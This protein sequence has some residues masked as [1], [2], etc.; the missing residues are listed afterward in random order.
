[1]KK[2][3]MPDYT[4]SIVNMMA[5]IRKHYGLDINY[6]TLPSLDE[7]LKKNY[8]NVIIVLLDGMGTKII[9][10]SIGTGNFLYKNKKQDYQSIFPPTT[11]AATTAL[12]STK[13]PIENGW[14]GWHIYMKEIDK[15]IAMFM[16]AGYYEDIKYDYSL[17]DLYMPY[18][19]ILDELKT[20]GVTTGDVYPSFRPNGAKDFDEFLVK[21]KEFIDLEGD[22]KFAYCYWTEPDH[23]LH[24]T[25]CTSEVTINTIQELNDKLEIFYNEVLDDDTLIIVT[26]DHGHI[27]ILDLNLAGYPNIL[28]LLERLP[29]IE[30]RAC[31]FYVKEGKE[32]EFKNEFNSL[33][34][35]DFILLTKDEVLEK[36]IFGVGKPHPTTEY[37]IGQFT[38]LATNRLTFS[39]HENLEEEQFKAT[40]AGLT[41][42]EMIIPLILLTKK[43]SK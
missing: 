21:I 18:V 14:L 41:E 39:Y 17:T 32:E 19:S 12:L 29:S 3:V 27:D 31:T 33:W 9:E 13:T 43:G 37:T 2:I 5:S 7:E 24:E 26:A 1:M 23:V 34:K 38:A 20:V 8:K 30:P 36:N 10:N 11:V 15:D 40:H 22:K 6:N 16:N 25:G 42:D 35:D 28:K 4:K